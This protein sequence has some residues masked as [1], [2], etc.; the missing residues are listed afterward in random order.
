M[1]IYFKVSFGMD[2]ET[3]YITLYIIR[4][5]KAKFMSLFNY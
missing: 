1:N 5:D 4:S 3:V 2:I